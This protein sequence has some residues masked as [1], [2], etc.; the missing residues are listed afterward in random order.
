L[1]SR[2]AH[3]SLSERFEPVADRGDRGGLGK[4]AQTHEGGF[5][6]VAKGEDTETMAMDKLEMGELVTQLDP[7]APNTE[8]IVALI[9][10]M[11]QYDRMLGEFGL[12]T[13]KIVPD[14]VVGVETVDMQEVH[15]AVGEYGEGLVKSSP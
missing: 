6:V 9:R 12:P 11:Q 1:F 7:E 3:T 4:L 8:V 10:V 14:G 13:L 2:L 5:D 15:G